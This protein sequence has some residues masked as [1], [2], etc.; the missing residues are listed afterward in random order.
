[1][2]K[3]GEKKD[4]RGKGSEKDIESALESVGPVPV[5]QAVPKECKERVFFSR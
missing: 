2:R 3:N 1:V 4:P 5:V